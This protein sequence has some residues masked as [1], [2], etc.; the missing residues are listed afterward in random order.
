MYSGQGCN[1]LIS[2]P[3]LLGREFRVL[4]TVELEHLEAQMQHSVDGV[5]DSGSQVVWGN[6]MK[7]SSELL[8]EPK[9]PHHP[10][11]LGLDKDS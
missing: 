8:L 6:G 1:E 3:S 2:A 9:Y 10:V 7:L 5:S 4:C 11:Q